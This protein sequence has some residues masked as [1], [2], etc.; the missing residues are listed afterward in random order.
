MSKMN[1]SKLLTMDDLGY[2]ALKYDTDPEVL[3]DFSDANWCDFIGCPRQDLAFYLFGDDEYIEPEDE[4]MLFDE[5][6]NGMSP[7]DLFD[8]GEVVS[9][10]QARVERDAKPRPQWTPPPYTPYQPTYAKKK[11]V[12]VTHFFQLV[13]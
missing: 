4:L 13:R 1:Y 6:G 9:L 10:E 2:L 5:D 3:F 7:Y 12:K 11:K 8:L